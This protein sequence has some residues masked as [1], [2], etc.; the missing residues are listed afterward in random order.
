VDKIATYLGIL[1]DHPLWKEAES[2]RIM[3][4]GSRMKAVRNS[5]IG[6]GVTH[7]LGLPLGTVGSAIGAQE[8]RRGRTAAGHL[9]GGFGGAILTQAAGRALGVRNNRFLPEVGHLGGGA[10]GTYA[11]HGKDRTPEQI[12]KMRALKK[13]LKEV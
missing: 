7:V 4:E 13:Q 3:G 12:A 11:A 2:P 9:A 10:L 6:S 5:L 1:E 8:G